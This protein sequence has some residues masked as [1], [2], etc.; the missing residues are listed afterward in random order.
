LDRRK[1]INMKKNEKSQQNNNAEP[2]KVWSVSDY[3]LLGGGVSL[4]IASFPIAMGFGTAGVAA[5][6]TAAGI[7]SGMGAV[8]AGS[9]FAS[10]TSLG[11]KGYFAGTAVAAG[12]TTGVGGAC[13]GLNSYFRKQDENQ[14]DKKGDKP[15]PKF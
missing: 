3:L 2:N 8:A 13:K 5:G 1:K 12:V 7:Q 11:M 14:A 15:K 4:A 9:W 10:A 6:S